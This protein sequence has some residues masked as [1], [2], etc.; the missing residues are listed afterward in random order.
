MPTVL[1]RSGP[2]FDRAGQIIEPRAMVSTCDDCG[3]ENA[4]FGEMKDGKLRSWCG[5]D[6]SEM[7]PICINKAGSGASL[8]E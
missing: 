7:K 4:A 2:S 6:R 8:F 1:R 5:W 3:T